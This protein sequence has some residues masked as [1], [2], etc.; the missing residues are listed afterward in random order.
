MNL[1]QGGVLEQVVPETRGLANVSPSL[2]E[3]V[4]CFLDQVRA[5]D[6]AP[7][8]FRENPSATGSTT[9][10]TTAWALVCLQHV[11][12]IDRIVALRSRV[13][14]AI[15][16]FYNADLGLYQDTDS[17]ERGVTG[18]WRLHND[19]VCRM[20]LGIVGVAP[21]PFPCGAEHLRKFP[22]AVQPGEEFDAWLER[23]WAAG[24]RAGTKEIFQ[25]LQLYS[26]LVGLDDHFETGVA[27]LESKRDPRTGYIGAGADVRLGWAMR[28]HR[29]LALGLF[30]RLG[31]P[32]PMLERMID[33]TLACQR[34]DGL[35]DDGSMCANMDAVHLLA[36]YGLR[37]G[38]RHGEI[39]SAARRCVAA[40]RDSLSVPCG[41]FKFEI[42]ESDAAGQFTNG[43]AFVLYT[44]RFWQAIDAE[45][46][47]DLGC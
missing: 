5:T 41:G 33:S 2:R 32:E 16:R 7:W 28:G 15:D 46:H 10:E 21:R 35:F 27:F 8:P 11:G 3:R 30:W 13:A 17:Q 6:D 23:C 22:W 4:L 43:L 18:R 37:T 14:I 12:A 20:A 47:R 38:Y 24:P 42:D 29:N 9:I 45:A 39:I 40:I 44:L 31:I 1:P 19:S 25:Y 34:A 26:Q 36:E